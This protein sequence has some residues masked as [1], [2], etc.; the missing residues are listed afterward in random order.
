MAPSLSTAHRNAH[1]LPTK[2][3]SNILNLSSVRW[4]STTEA[5]VCGV[6][7]AGGKSG[8]WRPM[9][10]AHIVKT[11]STVRANPSR[12]PWRV[13]SSLTG[14]TSGWPDQAACLRDEADGSRRLPVPVLEARSLAAPQHP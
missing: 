7:D 3:Y 11:R 9:P 12:D 4:T 5:S 14:C 13:A 10:L 6:P 1:K 8:T 2:L